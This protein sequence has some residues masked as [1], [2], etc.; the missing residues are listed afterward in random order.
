MSVSEATFPPGIL[1]L[2]PPWAL[3]LS[4]DVQSGCY[5]HR[6]MSS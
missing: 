2:S 5:R 6:A 4:P 3:D 1:L